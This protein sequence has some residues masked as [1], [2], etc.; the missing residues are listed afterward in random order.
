MGI[1]ATF[2][3]SMEGKLMAALVAAVGEP[4][5]DKFVRAIHDYD[6]LKKLDAW[7]TSILLRIKKTVTPS[8]DDVGNFT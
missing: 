5:L 6:Q 7:K 8:E 1:D 2:Q 4:D 3:T